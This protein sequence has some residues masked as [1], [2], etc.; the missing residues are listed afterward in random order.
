MPQS[1]LAGNPASYE[2]HNAEYETVSDITW[3]IQHY[4][5]YNDNNTYGRLGHESAAQV[6]SK[7]IACHIDIGSGAGWLL[8]KT[9][10]L[11]QAVIG[12]EPS[13]A[14]TKTAETLNQG[15]NNI[16][17]V[18]AG[19]IDFMQE[20]TF[21]DPVFVTTS[22]VLSHIDNKTVESFLHLVNELP[23]QSVLYFGEPYGKNRYQYLWFVRS[24]AWWA[25]A[26]P[27][28][29]LEFK[30]IPN[31]Q[32]TFGI[33]GTKV[34]RNAVTDRYQQT[35]LEKICW[36]MSGAPSYSKNLARKI[37]HTLTK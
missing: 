23:M 13:V 18:T 20:R 32:Y 17:F 22:T 9:A 12:V 33:Y 11:F 8:S 37:L 2:A 28:W 1:K 4:K 16:S 15:T 6:A 21:T 10:P 31:D 7:T 3:C 34:G 24:K 26:L 5:E 30:A 36:L 25:A 27:D 29:Q 19:M 35:T 14:A